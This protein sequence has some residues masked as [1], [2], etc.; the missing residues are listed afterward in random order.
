K[1]RAPSVSLERAAT[2]QGVVVGP[3]GAPVAGATV[4]AVNAATLGPRM[5]SPLDPAADRAVT[6]SAGGFE[7]GRLRT[8]ESYEIRAIRAGFFP[9]ASMV[10][11]SAPARTAP[12]RIQLQAACA[13]QGRVRSAD[14]QPVTGARVVLRP[15]WRQGRELPAGDGPAAQDPAAL[16]VD[17]GEA[18]RFTFAASPAAEVDLE[19]RKAGFAPARK[20]SVRLGPPASCNPALDLGT[21]VLQPGARLAGRVVDARGKAIAGA[22]VFL[23]E[24]LP[25]RAGWESTLKGREPDAVSSRDGGFAV[26]DLPRSVPRHL[27]VTADGYLTAPVRGVRL[28]GRVPLLVRMDPAGVLQGRV[29]DEA[30][31]PVS[32]ARVTLTWQALLPDAPREQRVGEAIERTAIS[33]ASGSFEVKESPLG[34]VT[35][36]V[37]AQGFISIED[38]EATVPVPDPARELTLV[39]RRGARLEGLVATTAGEPVAGARVS[40]GGGA[41]FSDADGIYAV[42][43]VATGHQ[44]VDVFHPSYRRKAQELVIDPGINR[45]DVELDEGLKV[46]GRVLDQDGRPVAAAQVGLTALSRS[47]PREYRARTGEDGSFLLAPVATGRYRLSASA[48]GF[49]RSDR[50]ESVV[51]A[52]R[53]VEGLEVVLRQGATLHGSVLGLTPEELAAVRVT[54]QDEEGENRAAA[55]DSEGRFEIRNLPA[56]DWLLRASLWQGQRQVEARV[57]VGPSDRELERDLEFTRKVSLSG[58]VLF[59][60]EPLAGSTVSIR[61]EHFSIERSVTSGF[62]GSFVLEDLEPDRYWLGVRDSQRFLV[63]ND[64]LDLTDDRDLTIRLEAATVSGRVEAAGSGD[65]IDAASLALRPTTGTDFLITESS[66]SDGTFRVI[67]I[68]PGTYRLTA[69]ASGYTPAERELTLAGGDDL[70][71]V[72]LSLTPTGGLEIQVRLA[73]GQTPPLVHVLARSAQGAPALAGTYAPKP[74]GGVALSSLPAGTWDLFVSAPG[75]AMARETVTVPGKPRT[76]ALPGAGRVV[77]RVRELAT[78]NVL[79]TVRL[80][81]PGQ[82][83]FWTLGPGGTVEQSWTLRGGKGTI[84]SVP[85]GQWLVVAETSD[86]RVWQ[87]PAATPGTG[88]VTL[89]LE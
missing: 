69:R 42:E 41:A 19:V 37:T 28:P 43:G 72:E 46:L 6:G 7:L 85:A 32:G 65:P 40:A 63:H 16:A 13:V 31:D 22:N 54:A 18:G 51:V 20:R 48:A 33:N 86:G 60:E 47:E 58:R 9:A 76:V 21:V 70:T 34:S 82:Q 4:V 29:V 27:L 1:G 53:P 67:H 59:D 61:G 3:D 62:D 44:Q 5:F 39:L 64:T 68:P 81:G 17:S 49:A 83:L 73:D 12:V 14:G 2:V 24:A 88:E 50:D 11:V 66:Q 87:A 10:L 78:Q 38:V 8:G 25:P 84:E 80:V 74:G 52:D 36:G 79:A 71:G 45:L 30:G 56:G 75:G 26:E 77:V 23:L 55:M 15:G 89:T 57:P 35:L